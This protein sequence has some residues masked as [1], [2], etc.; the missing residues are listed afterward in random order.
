MLSVT[1]GG[2]EFRAKNFISSLPIRD[3]IEKLDPPAPAYLR[4]AAEDFNYRDFITV[5]LMVR[6]NNLFPDNWIYVH[7]PGF[8]VGRIQNFNNWSPDL[9]P[10]AET[11]CL[12]LEYFCF[13]NDDFWKMPDSELVA[14]ATRE[15]AALAPGASREHPGRRGVSGIESVSDLRRPV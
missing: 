6:G 10:D 8:K 14:L 12:G 11:T 13:E 1:A 9:R 15:V 3:L 2:E 7:D 4:A 5:A